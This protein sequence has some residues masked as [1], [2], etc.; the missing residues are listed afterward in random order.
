MEEEVRTIK[1]KIHIRTIELHVGTKPL[2]HV[3]VE[4]TMIVIKKIPSIFISF[5]VILQRL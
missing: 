4:I 2:V 3:Q 5:Y 1:T